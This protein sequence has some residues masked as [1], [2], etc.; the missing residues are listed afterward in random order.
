V[1][2]RNLM[3]CLVSAS[4]AIGLAVGVGAPAQAATADPP[5]H[6]YAIH[7]DDRAGGHWLGS[8]R[9]NGVTVYR[10]DPGARLT[11]TPGFLGVRSV[12]QL[13]GSGAREVSRRDT[14]RAAYILSTYGVLNTEG[15]ATQAAAVDVAL[16]ALLTGGAYSFY[17][18]KTVARLKQS[19]NGTQI[20]SW[21]QTMLTDSKQMA[22]PYTLRAWATGTTIGGAVTVTA[23]LLAGPDLNPLTSRIIGI[24]YGS[25]KV[26][27]F[28]TD[29]RGFVHA[30]FA[31][32]RAGDIPLR[33]TAPML[34]SATMFVRAPGR[35]GASRIALAGRRQ[36]LERNL[37]VPVVAQPV[38]KVWAPT[39]TTRDHYAS[40]TF[41]Y[42]DSAGSDVR[43]VTANLYGPYPSTTEAV[44]AAANKV[45]SRSL[46]VN[47]DGTYR[48][49]PTKVADYG[50]YVW[51]VAVAGNRVNEPAQRCGGKTIA[52]SVVGLSLSTSQAQFYTDHYLS[53]RMSVSGLPDGYSDNATLKLYGP[54]GY[55]SKVGCWSAKLYTKKLAP[56]SANGISDT[57][58]I[59]MTKPGWYT[60]YATLPGS[61]FSYPAA[62]SCRSLTVHVVE[63]PARVSLGY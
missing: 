4:T 57:P 18:P 9:F 11:S 15:A 36:L 52:K 41:T 33:I 14:S 55:Q 13:P 35:G 12:V 25:H 40:G 45:A 16:S 29:G 43:N 26:V 58:K 59:W 56:V 24:R 32:N 31:A 23:R 27:R 39:T 5:L 8:R 6:G 48:L 19:G 38:V 42:S 17:G 50:V 34:P 1:N 21:A 7:V 54:F 44:C 46:Q 49:P 62:A 51:R 2:L 60:F 53:V 10:V 20:R 28:R 63:A 61:Q 37:T 22:G 47:A 30:T 3:T